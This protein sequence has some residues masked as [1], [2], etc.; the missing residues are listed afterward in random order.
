MCE[1][2]GKS[3]DELVKAKVEGAVMRVCRNCGRYGKILGEIKIK[4]KDDKKNLVAVH[5]LKQKKPK[6]EI[7]E[8]LIPDFALKIRKAREKLKME[9]K[10]FAK[11]VAEKESVIH[12]IET[13]HF[14]PSIGVVK[15]LQKLL[16][17][18]LIVEVKEEEKFDFLGKGKK[19]SSFTF[20]DMIK[21]RKR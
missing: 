10:E 5:H 7:I 16:K 13:G 4:V 17:I 19:G 3:F 21:V 20:G 1:M 18:K 14:K 12:K 9:Q 2:C 6:E 8:E 15:K 11:H